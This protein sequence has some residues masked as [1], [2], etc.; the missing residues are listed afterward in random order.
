MIYLK[1][2]LDI[3]NFVQLTDGHE[4]ECGGDAEGEGEAS[5]VT[6]TRHPSGIIGIIVIGQFCTPVTTL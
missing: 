1:H 3:Q 6:H 5:L 4:H 2:E